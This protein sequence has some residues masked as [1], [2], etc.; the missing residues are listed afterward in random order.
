MYIGETP[1]PLPCYV[2]YGWPLQR[3]D[4]E[5]KLYCQP[6][7]VFRTTH[8]LSLSQAISYLGL[9]DYPFVNRDDFFGCFHYDCCNVDMLSLSQCLVGHN[10]IKS[11]FLV[12]V[13]KVTTSFRNTQCNVWW[14]PIIHM[15]D[16][17]HMM[18]TH[19]KL[20]TD[21][22]HWVTRLPIELSWTLLDGANPGLKIH[23]AGAWGEILQGN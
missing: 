19:N 10:D 22:L 2:I 17:N 4:V 12:F 18:D 7:Q 3:A 9:M 20:M 1:P 6:S 14:I 16:S 5:V 23:K 11:P 8:N 21:S 13:W 15:M